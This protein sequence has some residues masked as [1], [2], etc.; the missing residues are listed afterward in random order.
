MVKRGHDIQLHL[1]P[2]WLDA[3]FKNNKWNF[4][5]DRFKLHNLSTE[6]NQNDINTILGCVTI[7]KRLMEDTI[8]KVNPGYKV[9]TFRAGG[10]IL[11]P[12]D[13]LKY[14]LLK[15]D[16]KIDSSVCPEL[17]NPRMIS[18][19]D[20]RSYPKQSKYYF[21]STPKIIT[22]NGK[23]IEIPITT[24]RLSVFRNIFY[25]IIRRIKYPSLEKKRKGHGLGGSL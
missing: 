12:F 25:K 15:N 22:D 5:Y 23:F 8:R 17:Y 9:T 16:I 7:S 1:H 13:K 19:Y 11:E 21:D 14:A 4:T 10:Y 2:H 20:F 24:I 18:F 3:E 6:N